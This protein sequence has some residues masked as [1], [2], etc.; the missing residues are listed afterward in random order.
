MSA[1]I[2]EFKAIEENSRIEADGDSELS[3]L[4][5]SMNVRLQCDYC[6]AGVSLMNPF[7]QHHTTVELAFSD[8]GR[9][10]I[11][12]LKYDPKDD[13]RTDVVARFYWSGT[14]WAQ[15]PPAT[16]QVNEIIDGQKCGCVRC[17]TDRKEMLG[18]LPLTACRMIVCPICGNKRCPKASDHRFKCTNSNASGQVGVVQNWEVDPSGTAG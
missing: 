6:W 4:V 17:V 10:Q 15:E 11:T 16:Q 2:F 5:P 9:P 12:L 13:C 8:D 7:G 14:S 3:A 18:S 1:T